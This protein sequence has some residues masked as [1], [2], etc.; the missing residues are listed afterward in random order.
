MWA[1]RDILGGFKLLLF[2]SYFTSW[3]NVRRFILVK[4]LCTL[5]MGGKYWDQVT[6]LHVTGWH[7]MGVM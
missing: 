6:T 2:H 5:R 3:R 7:G 1:D 4:A